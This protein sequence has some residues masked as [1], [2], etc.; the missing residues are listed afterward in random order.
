[1]IRRIR[2]NWRSES[3]ERFSG[4][5]EKGTDNKSHSLRLGRP[6]S[7]L[8]GPDGLVHDVS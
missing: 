2:I 8:I 5:V 6:R 4:Y 1:M 3:D 7:V